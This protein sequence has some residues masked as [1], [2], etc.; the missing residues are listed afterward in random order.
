MAKPDKALKKLFTELERQGGEIRETRKG[1]MIYPPDEDADLVLIHGT[2]SDRRAWANM[3]S[4]LR[5]S[6][7]DA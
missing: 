5:R 2:P 1:W 3:I 7:F 6:G 4:Q